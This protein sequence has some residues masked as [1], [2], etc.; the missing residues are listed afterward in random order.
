MLK[1]VRAALSRLCRLVEYHN[2]VIHRIA[3]PRDFFDAHRNDVVMLLRL[4]AGANAMEATLRLMLSLD[5]SDDS[6]R[7]KLA[8]VHSALA[9]IAYLREIVKTIEAEKYEDRLWTLVHAAVDNGFELGSPVADAR[10]LLSPIHPDIGGNILLKIRDKVGFHWDPQPFKA[11]LDD[12]EVTEANVWEA[13]GEKILNRIFRAS[14]DAISRFFGKLP[15]PDKTLED[16]LGPIL[17]AHGV[18]GKVVEA[19]FIGLIVESG[20]QPEKYWVQEES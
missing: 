20:E 7:T 8:R 15:G 9:A 18:V 14:A 5:E 16:L 3:L 4:G 12:P 19:A 6:P 10:V 13:D 11:F 17:E 2:S 1:W